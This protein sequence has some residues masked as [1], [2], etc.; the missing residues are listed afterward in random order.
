MMFDTL[1]FSFKTPLHISNTRADYG[2]SEKILH[3]DALYAAIMQAWAVLGKSEW[4]SKKP[5]FTLSS[6]F[7]FTSV[8]GEKVHFF[9][10]PF[11][12][13]N[14]EGAVV[15]TEDAKTFKKVKYVDVSILEAYLNFLPQPSNT[16]WV[17]GSY[18]TQHANAIDKDFIQTD[19]VPRIRKPRRD[20]ED[21]EPFYTERLY[22]KSGSG[23]F[24]LVQYESEEAK[25]QVEAAVGYLAD[26]GIGTDRN[27]G[28]GLFDWSAGKLPLSLPTGADWALNLSL[29]CP[30]NQQQLTDMLDN[31]ARYE[32]IKRGGWMSEPHNTYRKRSVYMFKEGSLLRTGATPKGKTVN[33]QPENALLPSPVTHPVWRVG[34]ALFLPVKLP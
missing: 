22:F 18:Q 34:K 16:N 32:I 9:P 24:C 26:T 27:V 13:P 23:L 11:L 8:G 14:T 15:R 33:L 5:N 31:Q 3:S 19:V 29:F 4:I 7:P 30:E 28:H 10:K 6:L 25:R 17:K 12:K 20:S 1:Y 2:Q 21:A